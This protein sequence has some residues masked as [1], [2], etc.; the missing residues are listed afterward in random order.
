MH[1]V[2]TLLALYLDHIKLAILA[3]PVE[4]ALHARPST[5]L[6]ASPARSCAAHVDLCHLRDVNVGPQ[7]LQPRALCVLCFDARTTTCRTSRMVRSDDGRHTFRLPT[8]PPLLPDPL[9]LPS[10]LP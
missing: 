4:D 6:R 7:V 2:S 8:G 1:F 5:P 9:L 10:R 3:V